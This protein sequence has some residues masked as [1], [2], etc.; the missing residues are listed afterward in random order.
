MLA[1][2]L[3]RTALSSLSALFGGLGVF[4]IYLSFGRGAFLSYA[5]MF[6]GAA[7]AIVV[8]APR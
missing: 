5:L 2:A 7:T 1:L 6:F 4:F 3:L 8:T